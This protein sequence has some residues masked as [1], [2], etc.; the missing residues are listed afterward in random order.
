MTVS[1]TTIK[2][3]P[4]ACD[5]ITT[6]F[7]FTWQVWENS[8]VKVIRKD[9][10]TDL[11]ETL[12]EGAGADYT[13]TLSSALPSAGYITT[14]S[15]YAATYEIVIKANFPY[16]QEVDY[17][18]GD[19]FPAASH[20]EALDRGVRLTQQ[21]KEMIDRTILL[22]EASTLTG[23]TLPEPVADE[24]LKW[25]N[26]ATA[27]NNASLVAY[28]DINSHN[29]GISITV[30]ANLISG[31]ISGL[32]YTTPG[33][34]STATAAEVAAGNLSTKAVTPASLASVL[35]YETIHVPAGSLRM[36]GATQDVQAYPGSK[37]TRDYVEMGQLQNESSGYDFTLW[38]PSS[39]DQAT[40]KGM[41]AWMAGYNKALSV[42]SAISIGFQIKAYNSGSPIDTNWSTPPV[43]VTD[44]VRNSQTDIEEETA[45][46]ANLASSVP[47]STNRIDLRVMRNNTISN[48]ATA[49]IWLTQLL[50]QFKKTNQVT[51]W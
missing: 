51:G 28:A 25:N 18:E 39:W 29:N 36:N 2:T 45:A 9:T 10:T 12:T 43:Y 44:T 14:T 42:G 5:G 46:S 35:Q 20:E 4:F 41:I 30:H 16:L 38:V 3:T 40:L 21:L 15:A 32:G 8:E 6:Q 37:V 24:Y 34:I 17:G 22:P 50:F 49:P 7:A 31:L 1:S 47:G 11:E 33:L 27:L 19:T 26:A 13:V 48:N 23:L